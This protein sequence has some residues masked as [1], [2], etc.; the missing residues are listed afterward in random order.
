MVER[1][2]DRPGG[3]DGLF[4][5]G[6]NFRA[7]GNR[8]RAQDAALVMVARQREGR[9]IAVA[10]ARQD[11]AELSIEAHLRLRH[12][13]QPADSFPRRGGLARV[14]DP[15]LARWRIAWRSSGMR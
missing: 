5:H 11:D 10:A 3:G 6:L 15:G 12:G 8:R 7:R 1:F 13:G 2:L 9:R 4:R 14:M